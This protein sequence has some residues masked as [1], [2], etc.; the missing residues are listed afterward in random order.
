VRIAAILV[1]LASVCSA[2]SPLDQ[3]RDNL[4]LAPQVLRGFPQGEKLQYDEHGELLRSHRGIW[5]V[6]GLV[7]VESW[8]LKGKE[9]RIRARRMA[10]IYDAKT[11]K[12]VFRNYRD[13]VE[14][15]VPYVDDVQIESALRKIFIL[16]PE[17]LSANVPDVWRTVLEKQLEPGT[18]DSKIGTQREPSEDPLK[19]KCT[20]PENGAYKICEGIAPPKLGFHPEP[21]YS[22]FAKKYSIQGTVTVV[23]VVDE[24]GRM[25]DLQIDKAL[26]AGL[27]EQALD[28]VSGWTFKPARKAGTPVPVKIT[29]DIEFH[30]Y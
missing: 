23:G 20:P 12:P 6:N 9:L 10:A 21:A 30:L 25:R 11:Q 7:A 16:Q 1:I 24:K 17:K 28:A 3:I 13:G 8:D 2:G 18:A 5:T 4:K 27:D 26:G 14:L 15:R 19:R 22:P 29:I